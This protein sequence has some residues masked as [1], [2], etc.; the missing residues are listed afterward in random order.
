MLL[1]YLNPWYIQICIG[2]FSFVC[3]NLSIHQALLILGTTF[4]EIS[5]EKKLDETGKAKM[6]QS[7][8]HPESMA[9]RWMASQSSGQAHSS[10][11]DFLW[12]PLLGAGH[13]HRDF[14]SDPPGAV[15]RP[16]LSQVHLQSNSTSKPINPPMCD[17]DRYTIQTDKYTKGFWGRG[18]AVVG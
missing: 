12:A 10:L 8:Y 5:N 9:D 7:H 3:A 14:P 4:P 11:S 13:G 2:F 18:G 1:F 16:F 15:S 17:T 6:K